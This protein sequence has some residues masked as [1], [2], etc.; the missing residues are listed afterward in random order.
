[1]N[2]IKIVIADDHNVVR[3]GLKLLLENEQDICVIGE[4]ENGQEAINICRDNNPDILLLDLQMPKMDGL[5]TLTEVKK[6]LPQLKVLI[7]TMHEDEE[8][9]I[10]AMRNNANGY[11]LKKAPEDQLLQAIR[12]ISR[13]EVFLD[14]V[15][16]KAFI[17]AVFEERSSHSEQK[18]QAASGKKLSQRENEV[19]KLV[20]QGFTDKEIADNLNISIKTVES[21]KHRIKEKLGL[22]RLAELI[23]YAIENN[24]LNEE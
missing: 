3:K 12:S 13:G 6:I 11:I 10:E 5:E 24:L 9:L 17:R 22:K 4:A 14:G 8:I 7:L 19:L 1:M 20:A 18:G 21:H 2:K 16:T 15:N 23:R